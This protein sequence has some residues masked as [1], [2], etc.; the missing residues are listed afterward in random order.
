M[1][2]HNLS[3]FLMHRRLHVIERNLHRP[4]PRFPARRLLA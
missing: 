1:Q 2:R 3:G 4:L